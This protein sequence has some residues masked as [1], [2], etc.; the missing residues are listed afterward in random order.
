MPCSQRGRMVSTGN[1]IVAQKQPRVSAARA[2]HYTGG[3]RSFFHLCALREEVAACA[4]RCSGLEGA[5]VRPAQL[6]WPDRRA[7]LPGV[8]AIIGRLS[9]SVA[10]FDNELDELARLL[11][12]LDRRLGN[13]GPPAALDLTRAGRS[14]PKRAKNRTHPQ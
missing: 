5:G 14:K 4:K 12:W 3:S 10:R 1:Q 13:Y 7:S 6:D 9:G 8:S 11:R 2:H